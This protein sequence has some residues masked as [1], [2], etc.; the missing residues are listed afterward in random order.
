MRVLLPRGVIRIVVPDLAYLARRY[1]ETYSESHSEAE[2]F[3]ASINLRM[4]EESSVVRRI[5]GM[6]MGYPSLHKTMYD[7]VTLERTLAA[8][9]FD[10]VE[11]VR[12]GSSR[13][14]P[15]LEAVEKPG[16]GIDE[17][18]FEAVKPQTS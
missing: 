7:R 4:P 18:L 14:I 8:H 15:D 17:A 1:L 10:E 2:A 13:R 3:L 11:C 12:R 5:Y 9:G 16:D 6:L